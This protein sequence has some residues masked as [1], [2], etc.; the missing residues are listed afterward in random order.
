MSNT[1][2]DTS[3]ATEAIK[4]T[5]FVEALRLLKLNLEKDPNHI[6]SLYLAAV[7]SRYVKNYDDSKKYI[8]AL[9]MNAPDMGRAYQELGHLS[10]DNGNE[11][12]SIRHYRQACELNPALSSC[13]QALYN[14]FKKNKNQPAADHAYMQMN[15]LESMPRILLYISQILNEGK[16]GIA[17]EKCREFLK[18][19]P[20]NTFAMSLLSEIADRL[21]YFDD[22]EFLLESAVKL[23]PNDGELRM[24]YA[25]ILRKKQKF[26]KTMEQVDILCEEFPTNLSY[27]AQK[28]SEIMQNGEHKEAIDL[29]DDIL[30]KNPYNFSILT[31]KGHA[32][33][34]LGQTDLAIKSYQ[35]AY[36]VKQ[37][38]GEAFFSLANLKTYSFTKNELN[39]MREQLKRVD[40]TLRDKVYFHF[41][42]AQGCEAINEYDEAFYHLDAGNQIK[43]KQSKYSIERM[44]KELQA[45]IDVCDE[46]FFE[47][48]GDGGYETKDP[49]FILGLPRAGSTLIE[50]IL[51]SHSMVDGTLE[52]PN[53]L[54]MAQSLRGDDIYGKEGNYPKSM[55]NLS[56]DQRIEM[57]S[58]FINDTRMHRKDAPRFTD[59]MPNN[60]RH[61]GLIHLIMPNAKIIDARR[62]PLDCCFSMF[63][64]LFAQGQE[65]T[66]G[67]AEAGSY[68][69]S[70]VKLMN[71]W[72]DVLPDKILRVNNEDIIEDLEGQVSRMLQFL[73]LPFEDSC[74]TF[75]ET[76]RSVRT[77]SSEQVRKPINKSG[78]D[79]WKPYAQN[80]KPLLNGLGH[81]LVK[82]EDVELIESKR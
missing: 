17:E 38:H 57:G 35:T 54:S 30:R 74:I 11:E 23:N 80:L 48:H 42:L 2:L 69:K 59:K 7:S 81:E 61:I 51:A 28:A 3:K 49:I 33:K 66:Y 82:P 20:T 58:R 65:F 24:K 60:F 45:Q 12:D 50:Q 76:D 73:D 47:T 62:Y 13:W 10:R 26:S 37:D 64:Q 63:K 36:N 77:A 43:N 15:T 21:G 79:R 31:S 55:K 22:A 67:L 14:Y 41:A 6:D 40:L 71:H 1:Q 27:Q 34:T 70:Y 52:L 46:S 4:E 8:E 72:D 25:M 78:M 44:D 5:R 53:I 9:L 32:Q 39:N 19:H 16:L 75:Y 56:L 29:F 18:K 68:Y